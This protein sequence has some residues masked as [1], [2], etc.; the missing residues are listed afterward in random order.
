MKI[1]VYVNDDKAEIGYVRHILLIIQYFL[2]TVPG[3]SVLVISGVDPLITAISKQCD[4][5]QCNSIKLPRL[6]PSQFSPAM[7][8]LRSQM[9]LAATINFQPDVILVDEIPYGIGNELKQTISYL[10]ASNS[11]SKLVLLLRDML[12]HPDQV[13]AEW[14]QKGYYQAIGQDYDQVL[15]IG[16]QEVWNLA[17]YYHFSAAMKQKVRF[18]GYV[19]YPADYQ[20]IPTVR[21]ELQLLPHQRLVVVAPDPSGDGY[22]VIASYLQGL[23]ML[24]QTE[25]IHTLI[26]VGADMPE[27]KRQTLQEVASLLD[28]VIIRDYPEDL[29]RYFVAAD[30]VVAMGSAETMCQIISADTPAVIIP[31]V[32]PSEEQLMRAARLKQ[33]GLVKAI[34]PDQLTP[35][36]LMELVWKQLHCDPL[37]PS[38]KL[39]L[40][41]LSR[42]SRHLQRL[43]KGQTQPEFEVKRDR[44]MQHDRRA[45]P[46]PAPPQLDVITGHPHP[47]LARRQNPTQ[48]FQ[49]L[50]LIVS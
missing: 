9:I 46:A 41:G 33:L 40:E 7:V 39:D 42:L 13:I 18:C 1:M 25:P 38:L 14:E 50:H 35:E 19:R 15:V 49:H 48:G 29:T 30:A 17:R 27:A 2:K 24:A 34:H 44:R 11:D 6:I 5:S 20:Q 10:R 12:D 21:R 43:S 32:R 26:F 4:V 47:S 45:Q 22:E 23:S 37:K 28:Q 8:R 16:M 3:V 31:K 36:Y